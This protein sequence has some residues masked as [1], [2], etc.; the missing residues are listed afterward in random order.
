MAEQNNI[1]QKT[2][3][4]LESIPETQ[5]PTINNNNNELLL[6]TKTSAELSKIIDLKNPTTITPPITTV[7]FNGNVIMDVERL[8]ETDSVYDSNEPDDLASVSVSVLI[9]IITNNV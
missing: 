2:H 8:E 4:T 6:I 3:E 5:I 9:I 7:R 1:I